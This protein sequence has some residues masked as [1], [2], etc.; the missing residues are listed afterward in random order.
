MSITATERTQIVELTT[1]MF[2]A[3]PGATYLSQIV[4]LYEA[5][6]HNL[7]VLADQLAS[8]SIYQ[9]MNPSFQTAAE[10]ATKLLTPLGLQGDA[11]ANSWI[12]SQLNAG[13][14]KSQVAYAAMQ[15]LLNLDPNASAQYQA[16]KAT[17]LNKSAVA[18]YYSA[19]LLGTA[20]DLTTLQNVIAPVTSDVATVQSTENALTAAAGQTFT[21]TTG[22]DNLVGGVG[23][24]TFNATDAAGLFGLA[25]TLNALDSIDG[26]AGSNT[27]NVTSTSALAIGATD[28]TVKNIQTA[29]VVDSSTVSL[30]TKNWS[31]LTAL[32]VKSAGTTSLTAA[33]STNV[34][35]TASAGTVSVSGG[36]ADT[37]TGTDSVSVSGA[38]G[39]VSITTKVPSTVLG[40]AA[41]VTVTGGTTVSVTETAGTSSGGAMP[42]TGNATAVTIGTAPSAVAGATT[43]GFPQVISGLSSDP[44]GNVTVSVKTAFTDTA[45][46]A[47]VAFGT[48]TVTAY[49]NGGTSATVTG[50]ATVAITDVQTTALQSSATAAAAPGTSTL[51][52]VM[53]DGISTSATLTS[54][55]LTYVS[56]VDSKG[57]VTVNNSTAGH[58]LGVT[59]GNDGTSGTPLTIADAAATSLTINSQASSYGAVNGAAINSGS[60]SYIA[61]NAAKAT[62]LTFANAQ[63]ITL[64]EGAS[65]LT[66]LATI[67]DTGSGAL[68]LGDVT[69]LAA[70][71][72]IDASGASGAVTATIGAA[73]VFMGGSGNDVVTLTGAL[74]KTSGGSISLGGGNDTLLDG[75]GAS[76]G[77]GVTV[78]GGSGTNTISASLVNVGNASGITNFQILDVSG[79]GAGAGAGSLDASLLG[80][81]VSGIAI[82]T[83]ATN[84]I[85]TLLNLAANVTITDTSNNT[86]SQLVITHA[87]TGP[88]SLTVNFAPPAGDNGWIQS[89]TSTGDTSVTVTSNGGTP[90]TTYN[91]LQALTETDNVLTTITASGG[92]YLYLGNSGAISTDAAD[93]TATADV[94][95][96]L[97]LIDASATTGGVWISQGADQPNVA[98]GFNTTY[99]G[100][101]IK[102]G[103]GGDTIYNLANHGSIIEGATAATTLNYDGD[104]VPVGGVYY[105]N[106]L[107]VDG[108][109]ST[110]ND[111]ASAAADTLAAYGDSDSIT[112]GSGKH[113]T[114]DLSGT[115]DTVTLGA[116]SGA[117]VNVAANGAA[118][119][120]QT[121]NF[122]SGTA[123]VNDALHYNVGAGPTTAATNGDMLVLNAAPT[124]DTVTFDT[125]LGNAAGALG[126]AVSVSS[127]QTIDQAIYYA[128]VAA[129][130]T[131]QEVV[132]FQAGG[133][134]YVVDT[135]ANANGGTADDTVIKIMGLHDLSHAA[136]AG[137]TVT[138]A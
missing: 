35:A 8:T 13:A 60:G 92:T 44:T 7:S 129:G 76:I 112:A 65:T 77:A 117:T 83:A 3:A 49:M 67:T 104:T 46:R 37:V 99:D 52:S 59:V 18:E 48:G 78:D 24:D 66:K 72:T 74:T 116:G 38:T 16:A 51:A 110:I 12:T 136:I 34:T 69:G 102:G 14:S 5:N 84:G 62:S 41:G 39:A 43:S 21:L 135:G 108:N 132:W 58:G 32:N 19:T 115:N 54:D 55:A 138:F 68:N 73:D 56:V 81:P 75:G 90:G 23:N 64:N 106:Y 30:N 29:N 50:A 113:I 126:A 125:A 123:N 86:G 53:L 121:V 27:L 40:A 107:E 33:T 96:S 130:A 89:I 100:L 10:F 82:S 71:T 101:T 20:T 98:T 87:G 118:G 26:G 127:A 119:D 114:V 103:T 88:D 97:K 105:G 4:A 9:S 124:G 28:V 70:L 109:N 120:V 17:L 137:A 61:L 25:P 1:L 94:A 36:L 133:N 85:A 80:T 91:Y 131:A 15:A 79:Y 63:K 57:T 11:F 122:G 95:S 93:T 128:E 111:S 6:G 22:I 31:G 134:T 2:N 45:G 47:D 42:L